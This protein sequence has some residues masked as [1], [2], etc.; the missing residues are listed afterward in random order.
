M[1]RFYSF[2]SPIRNMISDNARRFDLYDFFSVLLPGVALL[3]SFVPF[4]PEDTDLNAIGALLPILVGGFVFG[5]AIHTLAV[6]IEDD[7]QLSPT[8]RE[9]FIQELS[10]PDILSGERYRRFTTSV[11]KHLGS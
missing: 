9:R 1:I 5:R 11:P 4:L 7:Y 8:H 10:N 3:L 6:G 2:T